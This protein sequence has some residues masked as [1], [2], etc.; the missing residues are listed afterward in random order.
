MSEGQ[1]RINAAAA[2][3]GW[4]A[5]HSAESN[6]T[7]YTRLARFMAD[8]PPAVG[9]W[10]TADGRVRHAEL[11]LAGQARQRIVGGIPAVIETLAEALR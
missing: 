9:I 1:E 10:W 6:W 2:Q 4:T 8:N 5:Q 3:W 7:R 11:I